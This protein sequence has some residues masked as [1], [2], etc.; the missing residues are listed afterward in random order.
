MI[1]AIN[2]AVFPR[3]IPIPGIQLKNKIAKPIPTNSPIN[4]TMN[5]LAISAIIGIFPNTNDVNGNVPI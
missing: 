4:G 3:A 5:T 2:Q 1:F